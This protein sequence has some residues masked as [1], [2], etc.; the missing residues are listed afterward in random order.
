MVKFAQDTKVPV[1]RSRAEIE[2]LLVR[3]GADQFASGWGPDMAKIM[4]R[5]H[6]RHIRFTLP[7]P[8]RNDRKLT[9]YKKRSGYEVERSDGSK[10][11]AYQQELRRRW[12][13]LV[14]VVKAKLEAVSTGIT[15]FEEEFMAHIV[16]PDG[17]TFAEHALPAI[18]QVYQ[19]GKMV[20][21][22]PGF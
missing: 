18:E 8:N 4:F 13:A 3:Y 1:E 20:P 6:G 2:Q 14:L 9:H 16:M 17:K 22:L 12:R 7:M 10:E 5:A 11:E 21:L 19:S 15:T